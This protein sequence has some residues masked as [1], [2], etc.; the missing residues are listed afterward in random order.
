MDS[1]WRMVLA[2]WSKSF[3]KKSVEQ[4]EWYKRSKEMG[5]S[6]KIMIKKHNER[7]I[8]ATYQRTF[9]KQPLKKTF[10]PAKENPST[11]ENLC[12]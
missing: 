3:A 10:K 1:N 6:K 9:L 7:Y 12:W 5:K 11:V 8:Y 4:T 2:N